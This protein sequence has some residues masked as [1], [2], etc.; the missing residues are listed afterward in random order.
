MTTEEAMIQI[1]GKRI[2][3]TRNEKDEKYFKTLNDY[4]SLWSRDAQARRRNRKT[5]TK[6]NIY[7]SFMCDFDKFSMWPKQDAKRT[8]Q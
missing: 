6:M 2:V 3:C 1:K 5:K 4:D 7:C 8:R